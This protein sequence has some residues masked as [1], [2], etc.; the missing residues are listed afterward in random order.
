MLVGTLER[1]ECITAAF[2]ACA[3]LTHEIRLCSEKD[4][5]LPNVLRGGHAELG[6]SPPQHWWERGCCAS[7]TSAQSRY[8][9]SHGQTSKASHLAAAQERQLITCL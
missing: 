8:S 1:G 9:H 4:L 6:S 7:H 2:M 3:S 5:H